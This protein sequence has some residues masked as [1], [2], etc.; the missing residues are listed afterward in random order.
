MQDPSDPCGGPRRDPLTLL[1]CREDLPAEAIDP[2]PPD[3]AADDLAA[4]PPVDLLPLPDLSPPPGPILFS[5]IGDIPYLPED[6][7]VLRQALR[8]LDPRSPFVVH[9]GDIKTGAAPCDE[10]V[11]MRVSAILRGSPQPVL[12]VPG[13]NEWNDCPDPAAAWRLWTMYFLGLEGSWALPFPVT[14]Q[15]ERPENFAFSH[16]GVLFLGLNLVGGRVHDAAEWTRRH[17]E[18]VAWMKEHFDDVP[19][20]GPGGGADGAGRARRAPRRLRA[21]DGAGRRCLRQTGPLRARRRPR[22]L[23]PAALRA[24]VHR[25]RADRRERQGAAARESP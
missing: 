6:E 4:P 17:A 25:R 20:R 2:P 23:L 1:G 21:G 14:R 19:G 18:N 7:E 11:Y 16:R 24:E 15:Q 9:L 10:A 3:L 22:L 5:V 12:I 13:D 8:D